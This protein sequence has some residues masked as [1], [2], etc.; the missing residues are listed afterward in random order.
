MS[1][2]SPIATKVFCGID[3]SA[4]TLAVAVLVPDQPWSEREF[5]NTVK[6]HLALIGMLVRLGSCARVALESTGI[7]SMDLAVALAAAQDIEVAVL[8][9]KDV[10]RFAGT[11][12]RSKTDS[13]DARA[14]A[15]Y[16]LRMPFTPW[17]VPS[18]SQLQLRS[19]SRYLHGLSEERTRTQNRLH[20]ARGTS[21]TPPAVLADLNRELGRM[22]QRLLQLRRQAMLLVRSD[23]ALS[24]RHDLLT[25]IPGIG[26]ISAIQLLGE[27]TLL[28]AAMT[29]R[30][31]VAHSGLDPA[32]QTSG[33]SV[34]I[35]SRISR[36]GNRHLRR[37]LF[38]PALVAARHDPHLAAFYQALLQR[39]KAKM[40][41]L[42]A[43]ARKILHAIYG[44][45]KTQT[46]YNGDKLLPNA[47]LHTS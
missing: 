28:T 22:T 42:I 7:Y 37:A 4:K 39:H 29:I 11:L 26:S 20:A 1:K 14:L 40:Q 2:S 25:T 38:M 35:P 47:Q 23:P 46:P 45:L 12:R 6:G 30:Q 33:T 5:P 18:P 43:V 19:L 44:V 36:H 31:W 10:H 41:A 13:A 15:E 27:L 21:S 3:V 16:S 24:Q 17:R 9:P 8:N 32:H 34:R